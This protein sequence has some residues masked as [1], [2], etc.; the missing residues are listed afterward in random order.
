MQ[1]PVS[2]A[3]WQTFI[4]Q[5]SALLFYSLGEYQL[6]FRCSFKRSLGEITTDTNK[7]IVDILYALKFTIICSRENFTRNV[8]ISSQTT[9]VR[10]VLKD[11]Y[12][13]QV[14]FSSICTL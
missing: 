9:H 2:I 1:I 11:F 7:S 6:S 4:A 12:F 8:K 13:I 14:H 5:R 10:T 3:T